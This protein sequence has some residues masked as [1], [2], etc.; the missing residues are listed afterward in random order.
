MIEPNIGLS[1]LDSR[2]VDYY[3]GVEAD[4]ATASR[5]AYAA[6]SAVNTSLGVKLM[7]TALLG[8]ITRIVVENTWYD[9]SIDD[10][11]LTDEDSALSIFVTFSKFFGS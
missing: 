8:G 5:P 7:T 1:Y 4:E 6:D 2:H 3:Y 10:S 9:S 11:P